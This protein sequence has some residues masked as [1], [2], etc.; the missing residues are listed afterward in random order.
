MEGVVSAV[1]SVLLLSQD[2]GVRT[3]GQQDRCCWDASMH[4]TSGDDPSGY[5][6]NVWQSRRIAVLQ[7][8]NSG[9]HRN[10]GRVNAII[11]LTIWC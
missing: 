7:W 8:F 10:G 2:A 4:V 3:F 6:S 5:F 11:R 9:S 1:A